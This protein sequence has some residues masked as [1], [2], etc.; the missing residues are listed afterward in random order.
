M[1]NEELKMKNEELESSGDALRESET[2]LREVLENSLDASYKR[3]LKTNA[4][5]Y[6]SVECHDIVDGFPAIPRTS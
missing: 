3:N 5:D 1:H 6:L 4:Y 2:R